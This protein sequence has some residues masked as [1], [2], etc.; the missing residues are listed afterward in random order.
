MTLAGCLAS[1]VLVSSMPA[2]AVEHVAS[3]A[4][5]RVQPMILGSLASDRVFFA[6][7]DGS[8]IGEDTLGT[9]DM[10]ADGLDDVITSELAW[11]TGEEPSRF[12][13]HG[14]SGRTGAE[15]WGASIAA[16]D[17]EWVGRRMTSD[18]DGDGARDVI[19]TWMQR[20]ESQIIPCALCFPPPAPSAPSV[21]PSTIKPAWHG[22]ALSGATGAIIWQ[23]ALEQDG[24]TTFQ[25]Q[26]EAPATLGDVTGDGITELVIN[27]SRMRSVLP[28][29]SSAAQ[30]TRRT[31][32]ARAHIISIA[33]GRSWTMHERSLVGAPV[34]TGAGD[35]VGDARGD[36]F[37]EERWWDQDRSGLPCGLA[38]ACPGLDEPEYRYRITMLD[39]SS[40]AP[41]WT[42]T[43][44]DYGSDLGTWARMQVDLDRDAARDLLLWLDGGIAAVSGA[45]GDILWRAA[46]MNVISG[47]NDIGDA[48]ADGV[49]D[50]AFIGNGYDAHPAAVR[51]LS[52]ADGAVIRERT[53]PEGDPDGRSSS[54]GIVGDLDADG[55]LDLAAYSGGNGHEPVLQFFRGTDG[56]TMLDLRGDAVPDGLTVTGDAHPAAG[57]EL[58]FWRTLPDDVIERAL[59]NVQ[60]GILWT[61]AE[62]Y[63]S[64]FVWFQASDAD[65][66][67]YGGADLLVRSRGGADRLDLVSGHDGQ[68]R[69][70]AV[71]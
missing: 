23:M 56:A 9:T 69:W 4:G 71:G 3:D 7:G 8:S 13:F 33:E 68:R 59:L 42:H 12:L 60:A 61:R 41:A 50:L 19:V 28:V 31:H 26:E 46:P 35:T 29:S 43:S 16:P 40:N 70:S 57:D 25:V 62:A 66:D 34:L 20:P 22:E 64:G 18:L 11:S 32:E 48:N 47:I 24:A 6:A 65:M 45:T 10:D 5:A 36:L 54:T 55:V 14:L 39:G 27:T 37:W 49:T 52:G 30:V 63:A 38:Q 67:G 1:V 53:F 51:F 17:A 2:G 15:R 21:P 44:H 58:L